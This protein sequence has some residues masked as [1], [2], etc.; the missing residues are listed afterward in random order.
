MGK[1]AVVDIHRLCVD[2]LTF[3]N[4]PVD[5]ASIISDSIVYAHT[6]EKHTH[7]IGRM[8]IYVRKIK[9]GLLNP[10]TPIDTIAETPVISIINANNGFGQVAAVKAMRIAIEKAKVHGIGLVG[11]KDSNNF[12][13]AGFIGEQ[14]TNEF[15]IGIVLSNSAPAIAPTGGNKALFGTNPLCIS[16]PTSDNDFPIILDMAC[17]G[18]ARGKVRLA[19]KRGEKIPIGWAVDETGNETDDP[20]KALKGF[21]LPIGD[22]KGFG[23]AL[24]VDVL[25]GLI[26][27]SGFAGE[28][29]NLDH[30]TDISCQGHMIIAINPSFFMSRTDY[31][32]KMDKLIASTKACGNTDSVFLPGE[33]SFQK[34]LVN[35]RIVVIEQDLIDI[36][37]LLADEAGYEK[38]NVCDI[39]STGKQKA[40]G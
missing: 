24:C 9:Q 40:S 16:F 13:T 10:D 21:L 29:K 31:M 34:Y 33:Q 4:V 25:A 1:I 36:I 38:L 3:Y 20:I 14:A 35:S 39:S 6:R 18:V 17:S 12:G 15:M 11:V 37:N 5:D 27:G 19:A 22:Y 30:P 26:T 28:V 7:G 23:L 32:Q 2:I 8:E